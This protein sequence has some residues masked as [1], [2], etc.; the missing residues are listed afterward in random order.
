M[1]GENGEGIPIQIRMFYGAAWDLFMCPGVAGIFAF[2]GLALAQGK[3]K[4]PA[5]DFSSLTVFIYR[6]SIDQ[7]L[8]WS[9][10]NKV[11]SVSGHLR[12]TSGYPFF[13]LLTMRLY[14]K[15]HVYH[16]ELH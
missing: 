16:F 15:V 12:A 4:T 9:S 11:G 6:T 3:Q 1:T 13:A 2:E 7:N 5:F 8:I 14:R 10:T